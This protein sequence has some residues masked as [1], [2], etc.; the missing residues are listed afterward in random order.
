MTRVLEPR[1]RYDTSA[2][3]YERHRPGYPAALVDWVVGVTGLRVPA[4]VADIGCGTGIATRLFAERGFDVVGVD[5]NA[6]M[7]ALAQRAGRASYVRAEAAASALASGSVELVTAAQCFHWFEPQ[8]TLEE[9]RRILRPGGWCAALWNLRAS[10]ALVEEYARL[11]C[12]HTDPAEYAVLLKQEQAPA[13]LMG[14]AGPGRCHLGEFV[15]RQRLDF[16]GLLGRAWSSSCV[17]HG[18]RDQAAF[19]RELLVLFR[20][21]ARMG[22]VSLDYRSVAVCWQPLAWPASRS[23]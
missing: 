5:H 23:A 11:V 19:E 16:E 2:E 18:V 12:L 13:V 1:R 20:R 7:L 22:Q 6:A 8:A 9:F 21:H 4:R 3:Q 17:A 10:T 15:H 14:L